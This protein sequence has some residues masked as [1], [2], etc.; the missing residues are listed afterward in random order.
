MAPSAL[1]KLSPWIESLILNYSGPEEE[2]SG[3]VRLKAHVVQVGQMTQSQVLTRGSDGPCGILFLSDGVVQIPA[4]LSESAWTHLQEQE[5]RESFS[6]L[7]NTT[8]YVQDYRIRF[9]MHPEKSKCRFYLSVGKLFTSAAGRVQVQPPYVTSLPSVRT[10]ICRTWSSL[11]GQED[12]QRSQCGLDLSDLLGEWQQDCLQAVLL[13]IQNRLMNPPELSTSPHGSSRTRFTSW[14]EDRVRYKTETPFSVPVKFLLI[15]EGSQTRTQEGAESAEVPDPASVEPGHDLEESSPVPQEDLSAR[16]V[17]RPWDMFPPPCVTSSTD[18]SSPEPTPDCPGAS[19]GPGPGAASDPDSVST[20]S[21]LPANQNLLTRSPQVSS[22]P[23]STQSPAEPPA[24]DR[25]LRPTAQ[26]TR[27]SLNQ[28]HQVQEDPAP[29][30]KPKRKLCDV[31]PEQ[32]KEGAGLSLR[33]PSWILETQT[34]RTK[35]GSSPKQAVPRRTPSVHEDG[36]AFSYTYT[37]SGQNLLDSSRFRVPELVLRWALR[38]LRT[39]E[40]TE[41][42]PD[43]S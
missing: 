16:P 42:P 4:V 38:Y 18:E 1:S 34:F 30:R 25:T 3:S 40:P 17:S 14:D 32:V 15:P 29:Y 2:E 43:V 23:P 13:D 7:L 5:D 22:S 36:T 28:D 37:L 6:S 9:H 31:T 11:L 26:Q 41:S 35:E 24:S 12:S 27:P 20:H 8:V 39:P 21:F 10:K 33:P 19:S